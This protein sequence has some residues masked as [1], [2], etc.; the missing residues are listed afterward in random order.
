[1]GAEQPS[2]AQVN[3]LVDHLVKSGITYFTLEVSVE[4][5]KVTAYEV[6]ARVK[7]LEL[8]QILKAPLSCRSDEGE[9]SGEGGP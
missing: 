2:R 8:G 7:P 1:M 5:G 4:A 9:K 6:K 3:E